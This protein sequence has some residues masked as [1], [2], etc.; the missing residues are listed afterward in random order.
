MNNK[1]H[2]YDGHTS[3]IVSAESEKEAITKLERIVHQPRAK[4]KKDTRRLAMA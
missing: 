1:Y 2:Y 4:V 3:R